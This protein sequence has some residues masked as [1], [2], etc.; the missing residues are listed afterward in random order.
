MGESIT[1][2][3]SLRSQTL[4]DSLGFAG[5]RSQVGHLVMHWRGV[6][7]RVKRSDE[8]FFPPRTLYYVSRLPDSGKQLKR[9]KYQP[10]V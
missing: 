7:K 8:S 3:K 1:F 6:W 4:K 5:I 9:D 10:G 2:A